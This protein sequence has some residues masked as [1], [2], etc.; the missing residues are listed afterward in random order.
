MFNES[1]SSIVYH[2]TSTIKAFKIIKN[3]EFNLS[4][5]FIHPNNVESRFSGKFYYLSTTRSKLG[6]FHQ[7]ENVGVMFKLN[8]DRIGQRHTGIPVS[9]YSELGSNFNDEMEDRVLSDKPTLSLNGIVSEIDII[10]DADHIQETHTK[11]AY[12]IYVHGKKNGIPVNIYTDRKAFLTSNKKHALSHNTIMKFKHGTL[13]KESGTASNDLKELISVYH[14]PYENLNKKE[15]MVRNEIIKNPDFVASIRNDI[16]RY[17][18]S[19]EQRQYVITIGKIL[20]KENLE[21]IKE[22][23][24]FLKNKFISEDDERSRKQRMDYAKKVYKENSA[25]IDH[26]NDVLEQTAKFNRGYFGDSS[27]DIIAMKLD[28][29]IS[30]MEKLNIISDRSYLLWFDEYGIAEDS[31]RTLF[32]L[33]L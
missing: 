26:I 24:V 13:P 18:Q 23:I 31:Y 14:K 11:I 5:T 15:M 1:I 3:G 16:D 20:K 30:I 2:F 28:K 19:N 21:N 4:P 29:F 27:D 33:D 25:V 9:Y 7:G 6:H 17:V 10:I 32:G 12:F 22:F 8:G